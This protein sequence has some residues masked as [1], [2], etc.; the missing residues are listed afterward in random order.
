MF[1][2]IRPYIRKLF[3][4]LLIAGITAAAL[5]NLP[6]LITTLF[7]LRWI[8]TIEDVE[9]HEAALVYGAEVYS[10]GRP[11]AVLRDRVLTAVDL[12]NAG[13]VNTL[14]MSGQHPE[15]AVMMELAVQNGVP[16]KAII[17][18]NGGLRTYDTC[19]RADSVYNLD[20]AILITQRFHLPRAMYLCHFMDIE[21]Q[22]IP[23]QE[24]TYW[25]GSTIV[26]NIRETLATILAMVEIHITHPEPELTEAVIN[27]EE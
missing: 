23:A 16:E 24:G 4:F 12:Y 15:P 21:V 13:K 3:R 27:M 22:G 7:T 9:T 10:D 6:R 1:K 25:R 14:I 2:R 8:N 20:K 26:W 18:D 5:V 19:H 11:T 17:L